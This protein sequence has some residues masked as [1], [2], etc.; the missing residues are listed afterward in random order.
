M[1]TQVSHG[2]CIRYVLVGAG[3]PRT[4]GTE[5]V[6]SGGP[7]TVLERWEG[8]GR[9]RATGPSTSWHPI[10]AKAITVAGRTE[11]FDLFMAGREL[12]GALLSAQVALAL[13][14]VHVDRRHKL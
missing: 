14:S 4:A 5:K 11:I 7:T 1:V 3:D 13:S 12:N 2:N 8:T 6:A 9:L 10:A